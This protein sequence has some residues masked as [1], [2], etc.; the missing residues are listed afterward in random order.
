MSTP[1][2][3]AFPAP[4]LRLRHATL[5]TALGVLVA[6]TVTVAVLA[7]TT[8]AQHNATAV[9]VTSS[10]AIGGSVPAVRYLGPRQVS[11]AALDPQPTQLQAFGAT[12]TAAASHA[13]LLHSCLG[14]AQ[15]CLR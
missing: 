8:G 7:L 14:D 5:L 4:R 1:Q 6:I 15:R 3:I 13:A 10:A 2:T 11:A 9:P 12:P